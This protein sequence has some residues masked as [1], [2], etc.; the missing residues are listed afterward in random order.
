MKPFQVFQE[1][2]G[3]TRN[4]IAVL[5]FLCVT[6]LV[7]AGVRWYRH[8]ATA[9][10]AVSPLEYR[11]EDSTFIARAR[12]LLAD[13]SGQGGKPGATSRRTTSPPLQE[14]SVDVNTATREQLVSL[15]GIGEEIAGRI[16]KY[17]DENGPFESV[18]GLLEVKG[19]GPKK[20]ERMRRFIVV[21]SPS[22]LP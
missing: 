8:Q 4:E 14:G 22:S 12:A 15:P 13:T 5:L 9:S 2:F 21:R 17:R 10:A 16:M 1:R 3:F 18:E 7:G 20:L 11:E 6:F 19:I